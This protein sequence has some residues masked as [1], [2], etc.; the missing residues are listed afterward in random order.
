VGIA[1][2]LFFSAGDDNCLDWRVRPS[3]EQYD[4]QKERW[5]DVAD[6]LRSDLNSRAG[7]PIASWLQGSYKF[8]TQVRPAK[9]GQEFDI[10]LGIYF[11]WQGKPTQ[12]KHTPAQL[13]TFVQESISSY[14]DLET[15]DAEHAGPIRARCSRV[16]FKDEFHI[17]V[18]AYHL[19]PTRDA[20]ALA[21]Q[22]D[23][24]ENSDPKA[25]YS[26]WK[27]TIEDGERPRAR[28][29]VRYLKMWAALKFEDHDRPTSILLTVLAANA[30]VAIDHIQ[31]SGDDEFFKAVVEEILG[32]LKSS[33]VVANPANLDENLNRLSVRDNDAFKDKL[34]T[35][36]SIAIRACSASTRIA[37]ADIWSE[38][39]DHFFP[40][41]IAEEG[42]FKLA[43]DR[44]LALVEFDPIVQVRAQRG[45]KIYEDINKLGPIPKGLAVTFTLANA[46]MLPPGATVSWMV[47]NSGSEAEK[48]NDLGHRAGQGLSV[49]RDSQ[50]RGSHFMDVTVKRN[51]VLIGSRRIPVQITGLGFPL[52]NPPRPAWTKLR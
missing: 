36:R 19:D 15:N 37:S 4:A 16:H 31:L 1:A 42:T 41:P 6:H 3:D 47:R 44:A 10:D 27:T 30:Y 20:R 35:L 7:Y 40:I 22:D 12:G 28:R 43:E 50:Y 11:Q 33:S 24:W 39:F 46:Q 45:N 48:E 38:A 34:E 13:K 49:T 17:D 52:R 14:V 21:T 18:P 8:S 29:M 26:W 2:S 9:K 5:T 32:Q 51:G 23:K 25:I